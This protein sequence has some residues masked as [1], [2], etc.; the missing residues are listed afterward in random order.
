MHFHYCRKCDV[1]WGECQNDNK[2][3][4]CVCG[5]NLV[6]HASCMCGR[7]DGKH[8]PKCEAGLYVGKLKHVPAPECKQDK[9]K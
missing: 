4:K 7:Y 2:C 8:Y 3:Y 1:Y 9:K 6:Q 5:S